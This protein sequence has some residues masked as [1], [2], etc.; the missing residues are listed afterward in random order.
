MVPV[1]A[2]PSV[3]AAQLPVGTGRVGPT[4]PLGCDTAVSPPVSHLLLT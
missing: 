3:V 1:S 2:C 4:A